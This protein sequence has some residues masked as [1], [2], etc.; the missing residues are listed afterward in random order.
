MV[1]PDMQVPIRQKMKFMTC[2]L[3]KSLLCAA[4]CALSL[5]CSKSAL[6]P[7]EAEEGNC[8]TVSISSGES[9]SAI[10]PS[11]SGKYVAVWE[12]DDK[13]QIYIDK[14]SS[15]SGDKYVLA[16]NVSGRT[17]TFLG[18]VGANEGN[19][20]IYGF[21]PAEAL[22]GGSDQYDG[23]YVLSVDLPSRQNP[24]LHSFDP[25]CDILVAE[26]MDVTFTLQ[27]SAVIPDAR[28]SRKM[29]IVKLVPKDVTTGKV[30]ASDQITAVR[31]LASE[32][33]TLTGRA[34]LNINS[35][36]VETW[37][38]QSANNFVHAFYGS[39]SGFS[40]DGSNAAFLMVAP[41]TLSSGETVDFEICT[42]KH[43]LQK[44][45]T[46]KSDIVMNAGKVAVLNVSFNDDCVSESGAALPFTEDFSSITKGDN[47]T[48][49]GSNT[50]WS[51]NEN[52]PSLN[53]VYQAGGAVRMGS[54]SGPGSLTTKTLNLST[55]F[56]VSFKVK[57]WSAPGSVTV[58][59][60]S[61]SKT[62][63]YTGTMT[64][65]WEDASVSFFGE[66]AVGQV[67]VST[68][69]GS[70][71]CFITDFKI[72][73]GKDGKHE[74]LTSKDQITLSANQGSEMSFTVIADCDWTATSTD[75][76][77][78]FSFSPSEGAHEQ[79][80]DVTVVS[81][82]ENPGSTRLLGGIR[83]TDGTA[84]KIVSVYQSSPPGPVGYGWAELPVPSTGTDLELCHHDKLPS[85]SNKRNYSFLFD[86]SRHCSLWVAWPLHSCYMG[87]SDRTDAFGYDPEFIDNIYEAQ[88]NGAYYPQGGGTYSH[89]RGHQMPSA[90]RTF[91]SGDNLTTFYA[92]NMTP[93]L[94]SFNG[95]IWE[96][97]EAKER[98][99]YICSDTLYIVSGPYFDPAWPASYAWDNKG[100]GKPC[101]VPTHYWKIFL[102]TKSGK[103]GKNVRDCSASELQCVGFWFAHESRTGQLKA[104][105]LKSVSEI[106]ALT[107]FTFFPNVPNAPKNT[108][109]ASDWGL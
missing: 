56:T 26:P 103:T 20:T 89:S 48:T 33:R 12:A 40:L 21:Y 9:K 71:R 13:L 66:S 65:S 16:N 105:D 85:D 27:H 18:S 19:H 79:Y 95:N 67:T 72:T 109:S 11:D 77:F 81:I 34:R 61:Q 70:A 22:V 49:T 86:R 44:Q 30:L 60:G 39:G 106:E 3:S 84:T 99:S 74:I 69:S 98:T 41:G 51:G 101:Q 92:T 90:E 23:D 46:L 50:Q 28:F 62:V 38:S 58:S 6:Q 82:Q 63:N 64:G 31:M 96:T 4:L 94:Q 102:R 54:G 73:S 8:F 29:A 100:L 45:V 104:S 52:F 15:S 80:V 2:N 47:T 88:L 97:L 35:A 14:V 37:T 76:S 59:C 91:S 53:R 93:Q 43:V 87:S 7:S 75:G 68:V 108:Y 83:I 32:G 10:I 24:T 5:S 1:M 55:S 78:A 17:A 36:E 57:G 42:D 25:K 107:G